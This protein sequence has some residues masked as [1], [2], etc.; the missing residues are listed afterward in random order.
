MDD[1]T[2]HVP[3]QEP[4]GR[5]S[6]KWKRD[7]AE[8]AGLI[9]GMNEPCYWNDKKYSD[10]AAVCDSHIRYECWNGKWVEVGQC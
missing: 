8:A 3:A 9:P 4:G 1:D 5:N 2:E 6:E 10:G 7:D